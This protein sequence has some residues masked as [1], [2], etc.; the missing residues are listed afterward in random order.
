VKELEVVPATSPARRHGRYDR[1]QVT[2]SPTPPVSFLDRLKR[3][4]EEQRLAAEAASRERDERESTYRREVDPRMRSLVQYLEGVVRTL[5]E[6]KPSFRAYMNIA[7]YGD[8]AAQPMWDYRLEHERRH[9]S[10]VLK[11]NWTWRVDPEKSPVVRAETAQKVKALI[12]AF[13][14]HQLGGVKEELRNRTGDIVVA[15]F[16]ARGQIRA[17]LEAQISADDPVLRMV[18]TN[19]SWLGT[20]RRQVPWENIDDELFDKLARFLVR[21]DDTLFTEEFGTRP[22]EAG[23]AQPAPANASRPATSNFADEIEEFA[24]FTA[25]TSKPTPSQQ[26]T[27]PAAPS[28]DDILGAIPDPTAALI[29]ALGIEAAG[30]EVSAL[31]ADD[32]ATPAQPTADP[33][34]GPAP[35][36]DAP[37]PPAAPMP[38]AGEAAP[39]ADPRSPPA[40]PRAAPS[41]TSDD[42]F[43]P[44]TRTEAALIEKLRRKASASFGTTAPG[45][46]TPPVTAA[47]SAP[48]PA[49][50]EAAASDVAPTENQKLDAAAFRRRM[51]GMLSKLRDDEPGGKTG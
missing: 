41:P 31:S 38:A 23:E 2:V 18:F 20:S 13:R 19:A 9:R 51:S 14:G 33:A 37:T 25:A 6:L 46:A 35:A 22:R 28:M 17:S 39:S 15:S 29:A 27:E 21:E 36:V 43:E 26:P 1:T 4:A 8:L 24:S 47:G 44:L 45:T 16:H 50:A 32:W 42:D 49:P 5:I 11:L 30:P 7:G 10:W 40:P 3:E 48:A 34:P 12:S